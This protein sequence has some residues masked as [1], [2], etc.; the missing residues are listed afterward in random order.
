MLRLISILMLFAS[1]AV[2]QD[3]LRARLDAAVRRAGLGQFWGAV[4]VARH[5]EPLLIQGYDYATEDLDLITSRSLFDIAST[6]KMFTAAC[7]L[8]LQEEGSLNLS[9]PIARFYPQAGA[10]AEDITIRH[11][12]T[13]TS[14][15]SDTNG[16]IQPLSFDDRDEAVRRFVASTPNAAPGARF[17][18]CNG[19]YVVLGAIIEQAS[20]KSYEDCMRELVLEP[21]QMTNSGF[22]DGAGLDVDRQTMRVT[23]ANSGRGRRGL[24]LDKRIEP[25]AWGLRGAGGLVTCLDDLLAFDDA[26]REGRLLNELSALRW[27]TPELNG[28][29]LGWRIGLTHDGKLIHSHAGSTRG[30]MCEVRR[31]PD[32]GVIIAV[33]SNETGR[34]VCFP[35][36]IAD[37]LADVLWPLPHVKTSL[38]MDFSKETIGRHVQ[39]VHERDV[40]LACTKDAGDIVV[41]VTHEAPERVICRVTLNHV[42]ADRLSDAVARTLSA[43]GREPTDGGV[44][45]GMFG[46][47][48]RAQ[49][50]GTRPARHRLM[51][52]QRHAF[53]H[54]HRRER[55][56]NRRPA[57]CRHIQGC[58]DARVLAGHDSPRRHRRTPA[59]R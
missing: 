37:E 17:E 20:G 35:G 47:M 25:W 57:P 23:G 11:L 26:I 42:A 29:A 5:G 24:L 40:S 54:R 46:Y 9:D 12:L 15:R 52:A 8:R 2:A 4:L 10:A 56:S 16:A 30:Y 45:F 59:H 28:Y 44:K 31:Y 49:L 1:T 51:R 13:H 41:T 48:Y 50:A 6:S 38:S 22:L 27:V 43:P 36:W 55:E 58:G 18:Y 34:A 32:E 53:L 39:V 33:L 3:D 7:V 21:A 19:G 14:G